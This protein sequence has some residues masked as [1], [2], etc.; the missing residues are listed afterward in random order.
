LSQSRA[1]VSLILAGLLVGCGKGVDD[2]IPASSLAKGG[3]ARSDREVRDSNG[4]EIR[5]RGF[6]DHRNLYGDASARQRLD[7]WWS[8]EGPSA[9]TWRF[10]LKGRADDEPGHGFPV[11]VPNDAG[12]DDLLRALLADA[13]ENR[14]TKVLVQGRLHTFEAPLNAITL[15]GLYLEARSAQAI[16]I[17]PQDSHLE[18]RGSSLAPVRHGVRD[19][20]TRIP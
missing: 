13:R 16:R 9:T 18:Q 11:H 7:D 20:L 14:P 19:P 8:G 6:I 12:R 15:T 2:P 3:V 17:E 10:D 5:V 1:T 4:R